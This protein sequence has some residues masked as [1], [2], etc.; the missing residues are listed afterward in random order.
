MMTYDYRNF[1][2]LIAKKHSI[3]VYDDGLLL[4]EYKDVFGLFESSRYNS[5]NEASLATLPSMF[6]S[7]RV[8]MVLVCGDSLEDVLKICKMVSS[9]DKNIVIT[10]IFKSGEDAFNRHISHVADTIVF[11]PFEP[12]VLYKKMSI[13]LSSK[14]MMQEMTHTL[15]THKKFLD[16]TG[17]EHFRDEYRDDAKMI[18]EVLYGYVQ[19]LEAGEL[20]HELFCEMADG[21]D[22]LGTLFTYHHYTAQ[23]KEI[24]DEMAA[25]LRSYDFEDIDISTLEGFDYLVEILKDIQVYIE[26]FFVQHIFSDVYVFEHSLHDSIGFMIR[27]LTNSKTK[28]SEVEFF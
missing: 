5:I 9:H 3:L 2:A 13:A 6:I 25:F 11:S 21:I 7:M 8:D 24:F 10:A 18:S 28:E 1:L 26:N 16:E 14:M 17:I 15:H 12:K 4:K 20:S 19:R 22:S 27:R 23:L